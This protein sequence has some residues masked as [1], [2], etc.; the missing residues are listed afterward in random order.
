MLNQFSGTFMDAPATTSAVTYK[1]QVAAGDT[2]YKVNIGDPLP[3][4][5]M[6]MRSGEI[7]TN[8]NLKNKVVV[9]Q[10]TGSWCSVCRKEMPELESFYNQNNKLQVGLAKK[11]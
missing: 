7:W 5:K 6:E 4:L 10:F 1:L 8:N 2:G 9:L 11:H 3:K